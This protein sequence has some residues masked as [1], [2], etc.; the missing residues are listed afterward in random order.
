MLHHKVFD[1]VLWNKL[2]L[3]RDEMGAPKRL[4]SLIKKLHDDNKA[5]DKTGKTTYLSYFTVKTGVRHGCLFSPLLF[6]LH[7]EYIIMEYDNGTEIKEWIL[8]I[9]EQNIKPPIHGRHH[10]GCQ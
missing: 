8:H 5:K 10:T 7:A 2:W 9:R 3:I 6:N 4:I 1:C